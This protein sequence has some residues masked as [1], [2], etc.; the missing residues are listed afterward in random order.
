MNDWKH[1]EVRLDG[2]AWCIYEYGSLIGMRLYF[3][4]I[5]FNP[6]AYLPICYIKDLNEE[7]KE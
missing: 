6:M 1:L 5:N 7:G 2:N 3:K 4:E